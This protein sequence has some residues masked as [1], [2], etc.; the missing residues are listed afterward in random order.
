M[1]SPNGETTPGTAPLLPDSKVL[2]RQSPSQFAFPD[3]ALVPQRPDSRM[4]R[5]LFP[6]WSKRASFPGHFG[7]HGTPGATVLVFGLADSHVGDR[8]RQDASSEG[9]VAIG[10]GRNRGHPSPLQC[11]SGP[12][13]SQPFSNGTAGE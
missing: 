2:L 8:S 13:A 7:E 1:E 6:R 4:P 10:H 11:R 3:A 5:S 9:P 12:E